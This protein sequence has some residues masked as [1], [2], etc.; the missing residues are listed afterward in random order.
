MRWE[1][2]YYILGFVVGFSSQVNEGM[3]LDEGKI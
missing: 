1:C 3:K 2:T